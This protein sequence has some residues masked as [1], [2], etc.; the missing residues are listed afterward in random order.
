M[1]QQLTLED[2][3]NNTVLK[4][5][6]DFV[7][8]MHHGQYR[9]GTNKQGECVPYTSHLFRVMEITANALGNPHLILQNN[10]LTQFLV[11]ALTHDTIED[12]KVNSKLKLAE[13]L[14]P[15]VGKYYS[16]QLAHV[17]KELSNPPEGFSG[18]TRQ[19]KDE[20]KKIWQVEHAQIMSTPAK[21][22]KMADQICNTIDCVDLQMSHKKNT[23]SAWS[24]DKKKAYIDKAFTVC[25]ACMCHTEHISDVQ[26]KAL[27]F[28]MNLA[29]Q[30]H[31]YALLKIQHPHDSEKTFFEQ[32]NATSLPENEPLYLCKQYPSTHQTNHFNFIRTHT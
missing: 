12:T 11:I 6:W 10:K 18:K 23:D 13:A 26:K 5:T 30:A 24:N 15:I 20:N 7:C 19:E 9:K 3:Q 4:K 2:I 32:L 28:L 8:S 14:I 21:I 25:K 31:D 16:I 27:A 1:Y 22:I 29:T 17:V